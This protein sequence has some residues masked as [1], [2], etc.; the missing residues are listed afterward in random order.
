MV[1]KGGGIETVKS[2]YLNNGQFGEL[3]GA[4]NN[5]L[6]QRSAVLTQCRWETRAPQ[7]ISPTAGS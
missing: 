1:H 5:Q 6:C 4:N 7:Q 2:Y 3:L